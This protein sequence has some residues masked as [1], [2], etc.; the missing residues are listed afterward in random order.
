[1]STTT[2]ADAPPADAVLDAAPSRV[3]P[4]AGQV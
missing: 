3:T 2:D 1:M 4:D